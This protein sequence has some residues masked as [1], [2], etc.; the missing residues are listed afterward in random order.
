ML[1]TRVRYSSRWFYKKRKTYEIMNPEDV[2][3]ANS[4]LYLS[5]QS[6]LTGITYKLKQYN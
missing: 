3:I 2:G 5:S 1:C 4:K 6:G